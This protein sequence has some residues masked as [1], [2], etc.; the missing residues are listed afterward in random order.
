MTVNKRPRLDTTEA[1]RLEIIEA[2]HRQVQAEMETKAELARQNDLA[3]K[4]LAE[5]ERTRLGQ[6]QRVKLA[7]DTH[8]KVT[9][10]LTALQKVFRDIRH[11]RQEQIEAARHRERTDDILLLMLTERSPQKVTEAREDLEAEIAER[12]TD[13]RKLLRQHTRN[14]ARLREQAAAY[15]SLAVP[16]ELANQIEAEEEAVRELK[17]K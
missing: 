7:F 3:A 6:Q 8:D 9:G 4:T 15:G 12:E 13:R 17:R 11:I 1:E 16:L 14:L 5:L 10:L 2:I